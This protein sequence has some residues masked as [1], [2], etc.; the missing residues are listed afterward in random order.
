MVLAQRDVQ[1]GR[2][3][4]DM[5]LAVVEE[6]EFYIMYVAKWLI[7]YLD[8]VDTGAESIGQRQEKGVHVD[9]LLELME[10]PLWG[11]Y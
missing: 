10:V 2:Q 1:G 8:L 7:Y 9:S 6:S 5:I 11:G 3:W 4:A